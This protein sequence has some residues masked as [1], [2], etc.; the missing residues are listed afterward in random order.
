MKFYDARH[1][2]RLSQRLS[3]AVRRG[4]SCLHPIRGGDCIFGGLHFLG[5][6][7][8]KALI[9]RPPKGCFILRRWFRTLMCS[10]HR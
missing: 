9:S 7:G 5:K 2:E 1:R 10:L 3:Q 8:I 6:Y 4:K